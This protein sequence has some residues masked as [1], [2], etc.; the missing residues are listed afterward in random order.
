MNSFSNSSTQFTWISHHDWSS[1]CRFP[2]TVCITSVLGA[3]VINALKHHFQSINFFNAFKTLL[4]FAH[5]K[6]DAENYLPFIPPCDPGQIEDN[7]QTKCLSCRGHNN[8]L[9]R[10][11]QLSMLLHCGHLAQVAQAILHFLQ[12]Q[13]VPAFS[14]A[15]SSATNAP[16]R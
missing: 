15:K 6:L 10:N 4:S 16:V 2:S 11:N 3:A 13:P 14:Q 12:H 5:Q 9:R 7:L 8:M 1:K